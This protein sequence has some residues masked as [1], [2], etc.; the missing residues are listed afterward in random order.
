MPPSLAERF[1]RMQ[2]H[3]HEVRSIGA[4]LRTVG[5]DAET[6]VSSMS[7]TLRHGCEGNEGFASVTVLLQTLDRLSHLATGLAHESQRTADRVVVAARNHAANDSA[8]ARD[9]TAFTGE[10]SGRG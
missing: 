1:P 4:R 5:Q 10:L 8:R 3:E 7:T 2:I 6:C 9:F